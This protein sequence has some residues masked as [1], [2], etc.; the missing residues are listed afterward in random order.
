MGPEEGYLFAAQWLTS[1]NKP[2][3]MESKITLPD[4]VFAGVALQFHNKSGRHTASAF[5]FQKFVLDLH[6]NISDLKAGSVISAYCR[7]SGLNPDGGAYLLRC[8]K[9]SRHEKVFLPAPGCRY[10]RGLFAKVK[11]D[12]SDDNHYHH[13]HYYYHHSSFSQART[14][15]AGCCRIST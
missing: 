14:T 10:A 15:R 4:A 6:S 5:F 7:M 1:D 3:P 8:R 11:H 13:N 2:I 12:N 9:N